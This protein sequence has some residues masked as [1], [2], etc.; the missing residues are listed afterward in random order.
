MALVLVIDDDPLQRAALRGLLGAGHAVAEAADGEEGL[1]ALRA[2]GV[3][4]V[5]CDLFMP[6]VDGLEL[7]RTARREFPAVPFVAV[8]GGGAYGLHELLDV[9]ACLGAAAVLRKPFEADELLRAVESVL[10]CRACG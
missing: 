9:A 4:A 7:L 3:D 10:A 5:V 8:S 1:A 6:G 2:G